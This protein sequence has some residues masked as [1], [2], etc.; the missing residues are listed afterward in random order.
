VKDNIVDYIFKIK[1]FVSPHKAK[2]EEIRYPAETTVEDPNLIA[3]NKLG[4]P[5]VEEQVIEYFIS[6]L[7]LHLKVGGCCSSSAFAILKR[8]LV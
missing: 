7:F 4:K 2:I 5:T 1:C 8:Y 6:A 3:L